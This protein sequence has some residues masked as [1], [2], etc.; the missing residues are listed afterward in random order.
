M[1]GL[2]KSSFLWQFTAG[3]LLGRLTVPLTMLGGRSFGLIAAGGALLLLF[4]GWTVWTAWRVMG[5]WQ[6]LDMD[7]EQLIERQA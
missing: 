6:I 3:F 1:L 7:D 5:R 2:L 4:A